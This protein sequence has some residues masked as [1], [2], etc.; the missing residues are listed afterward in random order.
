M[1]CMAQLSAL[2]R[3]DQSVTRYHVVHKILKLRNGPKDLLILIVNWFY[4]LSGF[5]IFKIFANALF[6]TS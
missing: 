3:R 1:I 2:S 4:L 6:S 5:R